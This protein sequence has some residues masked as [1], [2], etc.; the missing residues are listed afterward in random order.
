MLEKH[1]LRSL[2][3]VVAASCFAVIPN[4]VG[5]SNYIAI[6][7]G[8]SGEMSGVGDGQQVGTLHAPPTSPQAILL[9]GTA[10]TL[11]TLTPSSYPYSSAY[12][13]LAGQQVGVVRLLY[14]SPSRAALWQ[15]TADSFVDLHP[16]GA[17]ISR[18]LATDGAQQV[19][20]VDD[21]AALWTGSAASFE[22]LQPGGFDTSLAGAVFNG[23]QAG[24]GNV[25]GGGQ[26]ALL[27]TG[28]AGSVVDLHPAG[29]TSSMV[30]G[31]GDGFQ[32][33]IG[34]RL[35]DSADRLLLW[36]G[37]ADSVTD[38]TPTEAPASF[39]VYDAAGAYFAG[40]THSD[41]GVQ[42][43]AHV[44]SID[45]EM[46]D[47][48]T[49]LPSTYGTYASDARGVDALG[50]AV[51]GL[52]GA[53]MVLWWRAGLLNPPTF[54]VG[55]DT[56]CESVT[57]DA[58]KSMNISSLLTVAEGCSL[59][60]DGADITAGTTKIKI[61]STLSGQGTVQ[62]AVRGDPG[63]RIVATG[64]LSL[65]D[66][67]AFNSFQTFGELEV[68]SATVTLNSRG[69]ATLG[70]LTTLDG[71]TLTAATGVSIGVGC[72]L[73]GWGTVDANIAAG[74]GSAIAATGNLTLGDADS[75]SGFYGDGNL[76][77]DNHEVTILD[78]N[79]IVLGSLTELGNET[80]GGTLTAGTANPTDPHPHFVVEQGKNVVGNGTING[81]FENHGNVVGNGTAI[82]ER[83][84]FAEGWTVSGTGTFENTLVMGTF[85]PGDGP[86]ISAG[87]NQAF[88]GTVEILLGG[89]TPGSGGSSHSQIN[90][91]ATI[92]LLED[93]ILSIL[94]WSNY[95]PNQADAFE[96][97]TWQDSLDGKYSEVMIDPWFA[98]NDIE[99]F[100]YYDNV[101]GPGSLVLVRGRAGDPDFNDDG[102]VDHEDLE[103]WEQGFGTQQGPMFG[104][105]DL[106]GD[107]DG[108]DFL[109]WQVQYRVPGGSVGT[110]TT[111]P[112]PTSIV[113][114][115]TLI[116]LILALCRMRRSDGC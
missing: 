73:L 114:L 100:W 106:D 28:T 61:G 70:G 91:S 101:A 89:P 86:S 24:W 76:Y 37:T 62:G 112:E 49:T 41:G 80:G 30:Y 95:K 82:N 111:V 85:A 63:S 18:A 23:V 74:F 34:Q 69:F 54:T 50:N 110:I 60:L 44:W 72:N 26:H 116:A 10:S 8:S 108:Y 21:H 13:T 94:P 31:L 5:Q 87:K 109:I 104:D 17:S 47:L 9:S 15:G 48:H 43:H 42:G 2:V 16:V 115:F 113:L 103:I 96:I 39:S 102:N 38:V 105:A 92:S 52:S 36:H 88:G 1:L 64:D 56:F 51:G 98:E 90:D 19:G 11:V 20:V 6:N 59:V 99:F 35:A 79:E 29:Y 53:I 33:G 107:T 65:G 55:T 7:M 58:A 66:A 83:I 68:G 97:M 3:A 32:V 57:V 45:G 77:T 14:S 84:T 71:G 78:R 81:N 40:Q 93:S 75:Y 27:W 22:N 4:A 67:D 25:S 12:H 46:T